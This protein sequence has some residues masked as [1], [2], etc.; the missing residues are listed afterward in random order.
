MGVLPPPP[1]PPPPHP[2]ERARQSI[3]TARGAQARRQVRR[4]PASSRIPT[5]ASSPHTHNHIHGPAGGFGLI[6]TAEGA[7]V[8]TDTVV[9]A[10]SVPFRLTDEGFTVQVAFDGA[11]L[12]VKL[13]VP[14]RPFC[15]AM[16]R[17]YVAVCPA[18]TVAEVEEP[19]AAPIEK[20]WTV[21]STEFEV[22]PPGAG[23][24]T[25]TGKVPPA[26]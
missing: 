12:Q 4:G 19:E 5:A 11:P 6:R 22:P 20:S 16:L 15:G 9:D 17:L 10:A 13:S 7:V 3:A 1:P 2:T 8:L 18:L 23:L 25:T 21:K 26:A 14:D 24:V